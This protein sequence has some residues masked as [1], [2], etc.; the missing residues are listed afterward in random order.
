M[1]VDMFLKIT[2]IEGESA[3][4]KHKGSIDIESFSW[5]ATQ[6]V[7]AG[8]GGG[9]GAGKVQMQ[10]FHFVM[11]SSK[12]SPKLFLAAATGKHIKEAILTARKAGKE[13][14]EFLKIKLTDIL[15]SSYQQ[16]ASA[17]APTPNDSFSLNFSK[18]EVDYLSQDPSG[19]VGEP[20]RAEWSLKMT[21]VNEF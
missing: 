7:S 19:K 2:D 14:I 1:A 5:G 13:Q 10:D 15:V 21:K 16:A 9:A 6:A 20:T 3:D 4:A 12:A 8:A 18:I 11:R 17:D